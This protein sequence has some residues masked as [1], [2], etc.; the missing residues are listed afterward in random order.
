MSLTL[1]APLTAGPRAAAPGQFLLSGRGDRLA[2]DLDDQD[3]AIL[4]G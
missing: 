1:A 4:R 2:V 3:V